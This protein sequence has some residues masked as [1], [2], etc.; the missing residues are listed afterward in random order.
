MS[1]LRRRRRRRTAVVNPLQLW[2]L[3]PV[4]IR[5]SGRTRIHNPPLIVLVDMRVQRNLLLFAPSRIVVRMT[6]QIP[7]LGVDMPERYRAAHGYVRVC[8]RHR[9]P[10][11]R[12]LELGG[13]KPVAFARVFKNEEVDLEHE[14]VE[15]RWNRDQ[16]YRS[17]G[18][19]F[20][21]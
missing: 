17:R 15:E 14:H 16:A 20:R 10:A 7:A 1:K 5:V 9:M 21:P 4:L 11:E 12:M 13:H 8:I 18:E 6:M 19:V 3:P 2:Q